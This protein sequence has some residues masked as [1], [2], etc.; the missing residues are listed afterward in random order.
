M[1]DL[2]NFQNKI[3]S[4]LELSESDLIDFRE[5][6]DHDKKCKCELCKKWHLI[7]KGEYRSK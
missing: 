6:S 4:L 7:M 5:A 1:N 2:N 3:G